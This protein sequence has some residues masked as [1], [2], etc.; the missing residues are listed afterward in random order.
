MKG[1]YFPQNVRRFFCSTCSC[2][3]TNN[4]WRSKISFGKLWKQYRKLWIRQT[5]ET[6]PEEMSRQVVENFRNLLQQCGTCRGRH[7]E[8]VILHMILSNGN[9]LDFD[10]T[11][12]VWIAFHVLFVFYVS[13]VGGFLPDP[14]QT[15]S[16][17]PYRLDGRGL[18]HVP[19]VRE[20]ESSFPKGRSNLTVLQMVRHHFNIFAG[21]CVALALWC[22]DGHRQLVTR[23]G[24]IRWV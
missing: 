14:A 18:T 15:S 7:L 19:R 6:I 24:I 1:K 13:N 3:S 9:S 4:N 22:R 21:S 11:I 16:S 12:I 17:L 10:A 2:T 20:V 23:F 8:D 5:V